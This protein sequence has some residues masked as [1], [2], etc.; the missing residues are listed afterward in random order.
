MSVFHELEHRRPLPV[1]L[2]DSARWLRE[3]R[4]DLL[5]KSGV[6]FERV[7]TSESIAGIRAA[8]AAGVAVGVLPQCAFND[9]VRPL[10]MPTFRNLA[11]RRSFWRVRALR[12]P[13][14][15]KAWPGS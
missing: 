13:G 3:C 1:A 5:Q 12:W 14:L 11:K 9:Q 7:C 2:F 15:Q 4:L 6:S 8:I 10:R